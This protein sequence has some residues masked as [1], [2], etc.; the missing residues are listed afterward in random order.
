MNT[1]TTKLGQLSMD[2]T[3]KMLM[4][5][6]LKSL[7]PR[8]DHFKLTYSIQKHKWSLE[9]LTSLWAQEE[10]WLFEVHFE[11]ADFASTSKSKKRKH[12]KINQR[13]ALQ[14]DQ[15]KQKQDKALTF[16]H[17]RKPGHFKDCT[18]YHAW[19]EKKALSPLSEANK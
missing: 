10:L 4:E 2:V 11:S 12:E 19:R 14:K 8:F 5:F 7:P 9:D 3:E 6:V 17:C 1:A 15:K 16:F 18:K 13:G